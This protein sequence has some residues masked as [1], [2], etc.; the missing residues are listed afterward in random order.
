MTDELVRAIT[1]D[2][3][4]RVAAVSTTDLVLEAIRRHKPSPIGALA[5][6]RGLTAGLLLTAAEK[7]FGRIGIQWVGRGP[8]GSVHVDV[9]PGGLVRGYL[10]HPTASAGSLREYLGSGAIQVIEQDREGRFTQGS[11]PMDTREIDSDLGAWLR[12]S[13]QVPSRLRVFTELDEIATPI[14]TSGILVQTLP[15]GAAEALLADDG[16]IASAALDRTLSARLPPTELA[17]ATLPHETLSVLHHEPVMFR[18]QCSVERVEGGVSLLGP[19]ELQEMI[20]LDEAARV[21]CDFC[22]ERYV[23][24]IERL[25]AI[26]ER[27]L[28]LRRP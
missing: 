13:E 15:G 16:P 6:A 19:E 7:D 18:C 3:C 12:R 11:L 5:L 27:L 20:D 28:A 21:R 14:A 26:R 9:R 8:V 22:A 4:Y 23:I 2:G 17:S 25:A 1:T 24:G 10:T